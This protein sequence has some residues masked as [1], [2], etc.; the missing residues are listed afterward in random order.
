VANPTA[1]FKAYS[2]E[3]RGS[4]VQLML[5]GNCDATYLHT[6]RQVKKH[7][8]DSP[9]RWAYFFQTGLLSGVTS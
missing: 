5:A 2:S 3:G 6:Y 8:R 1:N 4:M 7:R 9:F